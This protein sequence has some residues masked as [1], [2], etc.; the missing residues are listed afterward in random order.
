MGYKI[1]F[2]V[3]C[4]VLLV[5]CSKEGINENEIERIN[6]LNKVWIDE[7]WCSEKE[8]DYY[9]FII[10]KW[11]ENCIEGYFQVNDIINPDIFIYSENEKYGEFTGVIEGNEATCNFLWKD[12][13][14]DKVIKVQFM[15]ESKIKVVM[16]S[17]KGSVQSTINYYKPYSIYDQEDESVVFYDSE[18]KVILEKWGN[19]KLVSRVRCENMGRRVLFVY[20]TDNAGNIL[21]DFAPPKYF[22][23]DTYVYEYLFDD[24]NKDGLEDLILILSDGSDET[25]ARVYFQNDNLGFEESDSLFEFLNNKK[26]PYNQDTK[27]V[28]DYLQS[29]NNIQ[30]V[31]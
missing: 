24:I 2:V 3:F 14:I 16:N 25:Q 23:Y 6:Y 30:K 13:K 27:M 12:E 5:S 11:K 10:T 19:V 18:S 9:S 29:K 17:D 31:E 8:C 20:L 28:L 4:L 22:P 1:S 15:D 21:Y 26:N 7:N